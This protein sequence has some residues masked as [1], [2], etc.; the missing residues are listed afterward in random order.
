MFMFRWKR[1]AGSYSALMR[2]SL[3]YFSPPYEAATRSAS[4]SAMKLT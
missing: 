2:A 1:L 4:Y 3:A